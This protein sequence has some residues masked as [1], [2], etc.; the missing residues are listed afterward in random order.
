[1]KEII[2]KR[3]PFSKVYNKGD[4]IV[5][6]IYSYPVHY[7]TGEGKY[8]EVDCT[9]REIKAW[10]FTNGNYAN[11]YRSYFGDST[12]SENTHL[13]GVEIEG[14]G[15]SRWLNLKLKDANPRQTSVEDNRVLFKECFGGSVDVEY[16]LLPEKVKENIV[17]HED[18][19]IR[20]FLFTIKSDG[21]ILSVED[22]KIYV[23]DSDT[24][25]TLWVLDKPFM[26]DAAGEVSY[27][28]R[29]VVGYDGEFQ[30]VLIEIE[31]ESFM[32]SAQYPVAVDPVV[33]LETEEWL[34]QDTYV[35]LGGSLRTGDNYGNSN[36]LRLLYGPYTKSAALIQLKDEGEIIVTPSGYEVAKAIL[37]LNQ[38]S[39]THAVS[40][41]LNGLNFNYI[42]EPW[43]KNTVTGS[44]KPDLGDRFRGGFPMSPSSSTN[45]QWWDIDITS[46]FTYKKGRDIQDYGIFIGTY[47]V[48][49]NTGSAY[50]GI[51][52]ASSR[53]AN[54]S[55]RPKLEITYI[56]KPTLGF[57]DGEMNYYSGSGGD[58]FK[59]LDFGTL[60]AGQTSLPQR[61][62]LRNL[63]P[64]E[65]ENVSVRVDNSI[66]PSGV[67]IQISKYNNPFIPEEYLGFD[68]VLSPD[69]DLV[70]Y[71]RIATTEEAK[72]GWNFPIR[73]KAIPHES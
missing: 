2:E 36:V 15:K 65:V 33:E 52:V 48:E 43:N 10:E 72:V 4:K 1:M 6:E 40:D 3:T 38:V 28:V 53:H 18:T 7:R 46:Y 14:G 63:S 30:T 73:A 58:I 22:E 57:H 13:F 19:G 37:K 49:G 69:E 32:L 25:E 26:E 17:I 35:G 62:Y 39:F 55:I 71:V 64:F 54:I 41:R 12:D 31:D 5:K 16:I 9:I 51:D 68:G 27:G 8:E 66:S 59:Y 24:G 42:T 70:F 50:T 45:G 29:Y 67:Q 20:S 44:N 21:V 61:V 11:H 60:F 23:K 34:L 47:G 56:K